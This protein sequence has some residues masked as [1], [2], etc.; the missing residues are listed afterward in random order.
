MPLCFFFWPPHLPPSPSTPLNTTVDGLAAFQD[1]RLGNNI[2]FFPRSF[3]QTACQHRSLL[4]NTWACTPGS[5]GNTKLCKSHTEQGIIVPYRLFAAPLLHPLAPYF[6]CL[7]SVK[8]N[9]EKL[10]PRPGLFLFADLCIYLCQHSE[11]TAPE[12]AL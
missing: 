11:K 8:R 12:S 10:Q 6:C 5:C 2:C 3:V 1:T 9:K 7:R 4:V